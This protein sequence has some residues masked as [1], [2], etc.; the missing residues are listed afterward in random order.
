[1]KQ[2]DLK[3]IARHGARGLTALLLAISLPTQGQELTFDPGRGEQRTLIMPDGEAV[4]YTAYE[5]LYYVAN[6]E[7]SAYQFMNVYVPQGA[8]QQTPIL[9]R[10]YV[11]GYMA[12]A[13]GDP[14]PSDATGRALKEGYV[15][16]IPGARGRNST[17]ERQ[18]QTVQTGR[19][20]AGLLDLKAAVRYLR[21]FDRK[22]AGSAD[23]IISDGT[24]AGGAMS[25]LLGA[26]GNH[27][28]YEPL[29]KAMGAA[30]ERDDVFASV[31]FCP[32]TDLDHA[33]MA[34]EWL[35]NCTNNRT[36]P[37]TDEQALLSNTLADQYPAYIDS[38]NLKNPD[39]GTPLTA[40]KLRS[41]LKRLVMKSAQRAKNAGADIPDSVGFTF[42]EPTSFMPPP[43][44]GGDDERLLAVARR[45][46]RNRPPAHMPK[47][48]Q[49]EYIVNLDMETY[50]NYVVTTQPLKTPPAFS[51]ESEAGIIIPLMN[52]MNYIGDERATVANHWYIRH[53]ARDRD[54]SLA[55]PT[56][57]AVKLQNGGKEVDFLL[58]WNRGHSGDY[59][60]DELFD[61][62]NTLR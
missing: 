49:G 12:A 5:R 59:A 21:L 26:T 7:D 52:P 31:C 22:M 30:D 61:W 56:V 50:L 27:P 8:T 11:G 38:L 29:L 62:M 39:D 4:S 18:G 2:T 16:A 19:A 36:R 6:V 46:S 58:P 23:R 45:L 24:S 35:Y 55:V 9:M 42:S 14:Q 60:L 47:R 51:M 33:D 37:V 13:A 43:V 44:N 28:D 10:N 25:A 3:I 57:L 15:V 34:Y 20:P 53:G 41:Y 1:M 32:I 40:D 48:E 54:T 17:V